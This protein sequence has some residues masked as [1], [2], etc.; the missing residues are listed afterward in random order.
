MLLARRARALR[1]VSPSLAT[2]AMALL[3]LYVLQAAIGAAT[4]WS[5]FASGVRSAH[6]LVGATVWALTIALLIRAQFVSV[7]AA[8]TAI[9]SSEAG[10]A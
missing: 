6:L 8:A 5:D 2:G 4:I 3:L 9:S 7:P 10:L 1:E